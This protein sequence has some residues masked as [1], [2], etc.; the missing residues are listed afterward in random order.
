MSKT[1][2]SGSPT[3]RTIFVLGCARSGTTLLRNILGRHPFVDAFPETKFF[4]N[5]YSQRHLLN[6]LDKRT[7]SARIADC[8]IRS[9]YPGDQELFRRKRES[10]RSIIEESGN[11]F[12]AFFTILTELAERPICIEKTPWHSAFGDIIAKN[13]KNVTFIWV[14]RDPRAVT[15]SLLGRPH[16]RRNRTPIQCAVRWLLLNRI[17]LKLEQDLPSERL[18]RIMFE[19]LIREPETIVSGLCGWMGVEPVSEMFQPPAGDTSYSGAT[20][21]PGIFDKG[22]L[23]RWRSRLSDHE[24]AQVTAIAMPLLKQLGYESE[25]TVS[26]S[27]M[28]G[29]AIAL[30]KILQS[31]MIRLMRSG[32][33]PF[34]AFTKGA[35]P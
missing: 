20:P 25:V 22:V 11:L 14:T 21:R 33:Y 5:I 23:Q 27:K 18:Y 7:A 26:L 15:G 24:E 6:L 19:D 1:S 28:D 29:V 4:Q 9:E 8:L 32:F 3:P 2:Y 35:S 31:S 12:D 34:G 30:E 17:L 10:V 16:F 13:M